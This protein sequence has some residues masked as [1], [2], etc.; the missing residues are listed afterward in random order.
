MNKLRQLIMNNPAAATFASLLVLVGCFALINWQ[1][2]EGPQPNVEQGYFLDSNTNRLFVG[3]GTSEAI[4][5]PSGPT[6]NGE[7]AGFRAEIYGCGSCGDLEGKSLKQIQQMEGVT[8]A[9]L[10]RW[11]G[12]PAG[13]QPTDVPSTEKQFHF[14]KPSSI[15]WLGSKS[16][17]RAPA[18]MKARPDCGNP[19]ELVPCFPTASKRSE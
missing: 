9:Y 3:R 10:K 6:D 13:T 12:G 7:P 4:E 18:F 15:E 19:R 16:S 14:S 11:G 8:L 1:S 2:R 5:A 17:N